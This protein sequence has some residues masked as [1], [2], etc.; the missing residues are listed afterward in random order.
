VKSKIDKSCDA[1]AIKTM[2]MRR[3][4]LPSGVELAVS[5]LLLRMLAAVPEDRITAA[6]AKVIWDELPDH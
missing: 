3:E 2:V 1:K 4:G 5:E 6:E